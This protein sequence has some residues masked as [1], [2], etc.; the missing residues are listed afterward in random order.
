MKMSEA[1]EIIDGKPKGFMV[2]FEVTSGSIAGSNHFPDLHAGEP[3]IPT[4]HEAWDLARRFANATGPEYNCIYV[5][6]HRFVP[7][8]DYRRRAYKW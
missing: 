5:I 4:E 3:L 1:L 2:H 7:V 8:K 6:D